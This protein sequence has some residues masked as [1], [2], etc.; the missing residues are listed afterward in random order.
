MSG[1]KGMKWEQE[2]Q[3]RR[4][5]ERGTEDATGKV[6]LHMSRQA[7]EAM[8]VNAARGGVSRKTLDWLA[9][10]EPP[11]PDPVDAETPDRSD[12]HLAVLGTYEPTA[13]YYG[14]G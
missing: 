7:K 3:R 11:L 4:M 14:E 9:N 12:W 10:P 8:L 1:N 5:A 6:E 2:N 13:A